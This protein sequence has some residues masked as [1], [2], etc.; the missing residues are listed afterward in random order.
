M[1]LSIM[2]RAT[3]PV[4]RTIVARPDS[5]IHRFCRLLDAARL[6]ADNPAQYSAGLRKI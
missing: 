2:P 4:F 6:G 5:P 1:R 3:A